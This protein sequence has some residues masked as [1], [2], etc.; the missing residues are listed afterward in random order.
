MFKNYIPAFLLAGGIT[1]VLTPLVRLLSLKMG[2]LDKPNWRKLNKKPMPLLG[3]IAIYSGFL[4]SMLVVILKEP[5]LSDARRLFGVLGCAFIIVLAGIVDDIK[6]LTAFRKLSCQIIAATIVSLFG[7]TIMKVSNPLGGSFYISAIESMVLTIF[8]I[9]GFT[10]AI[11]LIDGLDGLSSGVVAIISG[12]LFFMAIKTNNHVAAILAITI[13]GS[14]LGF[15]PHNF[16]PAKIFMGDTGSMLLGFI[17]SLISMESTQKGTTFLTF[18][19]PVIAMGIPFIDT[20]LSIVRR[21]VNGQKIFAAD[22]EHI[23][24]LLLAY[25]G[26]QKEA[27]TRLYFLTFCFGLIAIGLSGMQGIFAIFCLI[28][29]LIVTARMLK[30]FGF[31]EFL[32]K[33]K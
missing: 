5:F 16:Y 30:R 21:F 20:A 6:G 19:I 4:V 26:T 1:F 13:C 9:V 3:G 25:E 8:W 33:N 24:H 17:L 15:L 22:K 18:F 7:F 12:T 29:F 23:H 27:V 10:N 28:I 32:N 11:N 31:L 14:S 2:W